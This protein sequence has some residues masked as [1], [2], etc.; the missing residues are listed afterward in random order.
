[1]YDFTRSKNCSAAYCRRETHHLNAHL[2][3]FITNQNV[4]CEHCDMQK[5]QF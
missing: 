1:M 5:C 3:K 2:N 4:V